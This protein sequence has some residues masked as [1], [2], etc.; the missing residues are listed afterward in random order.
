MGLPRGQGASPTERMKYSGA[1]RDNN[2]F[3]LT[4]RA[5][6][7]L[8]RRETWATLRY[9]SLEDVLNLSAGQ[10]SCTAMMATMVSRKPASCGCCGQTILVKSSSQAQKPTAVPIKLATSVIFQV[11][12][13]APSVP[14]RRK[15]SYP[16][17]TDTSPLA[18]RLGE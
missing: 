18:C 7:G 9:R 16:Q 8:E 1:P 6:P 13:D 2:F 17:I 10:T 3:A 15:S 5:Y 14:T 4:R 11:V 12:M